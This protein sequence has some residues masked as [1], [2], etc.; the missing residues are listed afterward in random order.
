MPDRG[1]AIDSIRLVTLDGERS[2]EDLPA[3]REVEIRVNVT[4]PGDSGGDETRE[5]TGPSAVL[6]TL[7][8]TVFGVDE[9]RDDDEAGP[10]TSGEDGREGSDR[11][12]I[13][14]GRVTFRIDANRGADDGDDWV[15]SVFAAAWPYL[16]SHTISHAQLLGMGQIPVPLHAPDGLTQEPRVEDVR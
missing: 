15:P 8:L 14:S 3:L 11:T 7:L 1:P 13:Y 4:V 10:S 5:E 6:A 12:P 9:D 16:R 2:H